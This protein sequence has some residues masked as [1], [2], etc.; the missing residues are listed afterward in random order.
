MLVMRNMIGIGIVNECP[1]FSFR[2]LHSLTEVKSL[3]S[4]GDIFSM[5]WYELSDHRISIREWIQRSRIADLS[6]VPKV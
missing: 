1:A 3:D 4:N 6:K 5:D 2:F